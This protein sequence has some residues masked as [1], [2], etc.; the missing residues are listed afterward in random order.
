[1]RELDKEEIKKIFE[2]IDLKIMLSEEIVNYNK[3]VEMEN[4]INGTGH[5]FHMGMYGLVQ[6]K[7]TNI[8][9]LIEKIKKRTDELI[10]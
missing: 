8:D 10:G 5:G 2:V 6:E 3:A 4:N 1:M 9:L 7:K